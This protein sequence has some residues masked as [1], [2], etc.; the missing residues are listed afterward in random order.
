MDVS[1]H[2]YNIYGEPSGTIHTATDLTF[3]L[4]TPVQL[5]ILNSWNKQKKSKNVGRPVVSNSL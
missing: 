3:S 5:R 4:Q 2:P 1:S